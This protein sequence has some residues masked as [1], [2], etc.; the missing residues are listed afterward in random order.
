MHRLSV[1]F[2]ELKSFERTIHDPGQTSWGEGGGGEGSKDNFRGGSKIFMR[3][4]SRFVKISRVA[5][6]F[7]LNAIFG[8]N[9]P[10]LA[11]KKFGGG[12]G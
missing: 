6:M 1:S 9:F 4:Y 10:F 8:P 7:F 5:K 12:Q 3:F 11:L 2:Y